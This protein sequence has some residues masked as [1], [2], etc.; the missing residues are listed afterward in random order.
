MNNHFI[1][2][3]KRKIPWEN[4]A[5]N[6]VEIFVDFL[7]ENLDDQDKVITTRPLA[8]LQLEGHQ[9]LF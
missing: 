1:E 4:I 6:F 5:E 3:E 2:K 8:Q 9:P 7:V